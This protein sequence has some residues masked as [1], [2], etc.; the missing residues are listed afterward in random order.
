MQA[1]KVHA[2]ERDTPMR[3]AHPV[4]CTPIRYT[5]CEMHASER[6]VLARSLDFKNSF[7]ENLPYNPT[8]VSRFTSHPRDIYIHRIFFILVN[9][10][11]RGDPY[12]IQ[13][14]TMREPR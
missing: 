2:R 6:C 5:L 1:F 9:I 12:L 10:E 13:F 7:G 14:I 3:C 4:K 8:V 11:F